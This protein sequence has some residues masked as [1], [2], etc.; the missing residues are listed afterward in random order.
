MSSDE[1]RLV[2][3]EAQVK[4][5]YAKFRSHTHVQPPVPDTP[6]NR[7]LGRVLCCS[8]CGKS[9]K[10]V[11]KLIAGPQSYICDECVILSMD[12][13]CEEND[14]AELR[15]QLTMTE[16]WE[17]G[18]DERRDLRACVGGILGYIPKKEEEK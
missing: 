11:A 6:L 16:N 4:D 17:L 9:Q 12:I 10:E 2:A 13:I 18:E 1:G 15:R 5:L 14:Y 8:F 3:L 7:A